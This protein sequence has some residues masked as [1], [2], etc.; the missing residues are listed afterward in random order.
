MQ[1]LQLMSVRRASNEQTLELP[2]WIAGLLP[3]CSGVKCTDVA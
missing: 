3:E 1:L 2:I